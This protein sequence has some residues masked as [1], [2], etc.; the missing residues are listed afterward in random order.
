MW[1]Q[2]FID[3]SRGI[4]EVFEK[5]EGEPLCVTHLYSSYDERGNTFAS[6]FTSDYRVYLVN[7]RGCGNS[8]KAETKNQF[9]FNTNILSRMD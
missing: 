3:T 1:I 4:F 7:L 9:S 5:G 8:V 2:R 6:P